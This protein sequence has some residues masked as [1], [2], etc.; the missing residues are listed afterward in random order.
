MFSDVLN[1]YT[2]CC[3]RYAAAYPDMVGAANIR[4]LTAVGGSLRSL[5]SIC[6]SVKR[7]ALDR[8]SVLSKLL[9]GRERSVD[10]LLKDVDSELGCDTSHGFSSVDLGFS[11][12]LEAREDD[13]SI[14]HASP[15]SFHVPSPRRPKVYVSSAHTS[16]APSSSAATSVS[17]SSSRR[18]PEI[19]PIRS[20]SSLSRTTTMTLAKTLD[21]ASAALDKQYKQN[22]VLYANTLVKIIKSCDNILILHGEIVRNLQLAQ[23]YAEELDSWTHRPELAVDAVNKRIAAHDALAHR[24]EMARKKLE[25]LSC[26]LAERE[27]LH[28]SDSDVGEL[29]NIIYQNHKIFGEKSWFVGLQQK[30]E[31][32]KSLF[33]STDA[34]DVASRLQRLNSTLNNV[35]DNLNAIV[36]RVNADIGTEK[37]RRAAIADVQAK[38]DAALRIAQSNYRNIIAKG[39][40]TFRK[41]STARGTAIQPSATQVLKDVSA[42]MTPLWQRLTIAS[43]EVGK[44]QKDI[45]KLAPSDINLTQT[46]PAYIIIGGVHIQCGP[47][48]IITPVLT[49]FPFARPRLFRDIEQIAPFLLR[50]IYALPV[51][52]IRLNIIDHAAVGAHGRDFN[53]LLDVVGDVVKIV[54]VQDDIRTSLQNVLTYMGD[55]PKTKFTGTITSW[56]EYNAKNPR[57]PLP[58]TIIVIYSFKGW[59]YREIELLEPIL[60]RGAQCGV[61]VVGGVDG[62]KDL[63]ERLRNSLKLDQFSLMPPDLVKS[64]FSYKKLSASW[65]PIAKAHPSQWEKLMTAYKNAY[66]IKTS[67]TSHS[68]ADLYSDVAFWSCNSTNGLDAIIGWDS[69]DTPQHLHLGFSKE[70]LH[71]A[72]MGG[73][74]G[75]GKTNLIHVIIRSLCYRY[76]PEELTLYLLDF[77]DG[78]EFF[79]YSDSGKSWL[80]H[81]RTISAHNDP[82]YALAMLEAI[83]AEMEK[84]NDIFKTSG[85]VGLEEYRLKTHKKMSRILIIV[86]EFTVMFSSEDSKERIADLVSAILKRGRSTGIH[87]MLATQTV[88]SFS[89]HGAEEMFQQLA[90]RLALPGD[91]SEGILSGMDHSEVRSIRIPQCIYNDNAGAPGCNHIFVHPE[92]KMDDSSSV[93][94]RRKMELGVGKLGG[95]THFPCRVFN[96][97]VL[98]QMPS[99]EQFNA[100][101]GK[102]LT[103]KKR[104]DFILGIHSNFAGNACRVTFEDEATEDHLLIAYGK[105]DRGAAKGLWESILRSLAALPDKAVLLYDPTRSNLLRLSSGF[106]VANADTGRNEL[107][108]KM[109]RLRDSGATHKVMIVENFDSARYLHQKNSSAMSW[110]DDD[111]K[112]T[113]STDAMFKSAFE[114]S[115]NMPFHVVCFTR[116]AKFAMEKLGNFIMQRI[117]KRIAFSL[118]GDDLIELMPSARGIDAS[119]KILF[120]DESSPDG[121]IDILPYQSTLKV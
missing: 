59:E 47:S 54:T 81:A 33:G 70:G 18:S 73:R 8:A 101:L 84:R 28:R 72:L 119:D 37:G 21:A 52:G 38:L 96:G 6:A 92:F 45:V 20:E 26:R 87:L 120:S 105:D 10:E 3:K 49:K 86:D 93:E 30:L 27:S 64:G 40:L 77:K 43:Q 110:D 15:A 62:L 66:E 80:P 39:T 7:N 99:K 76:S 67:R 19:S 11:R 41:L 16:H 36:T 55:L 111:T 24:V 102:V 118:A 13:A 71:Y 2:S 79:R 82:N 106:D 1:S 91:G 85:V 29:E 98:P 97:T 74:T 14:G 107:L 113:D 17:T 12:S 65:H 51:G 115:D 31:S 63:D 42:T 109:K 57:S 104:F 112:V 44:L 32:F 83:V 89:V 58:C 108:A 90:V 61:F 48:S 4:H 121:I 114:D 34:R 56:S 75:S 46:F 9:A 68:F 5:G 103:G 23:K 35:V 95:W 25:S 78:V 116:R 53:Q 50:L 69:S 117:S 100:L 88:A 94:F 60:A 22:F